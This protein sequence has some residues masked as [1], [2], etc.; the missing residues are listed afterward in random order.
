MIMN[1]EGHAAG[2]LT[3]ACNLYLFT[4]VLSF[5]AIVKQ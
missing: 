1:Y 4:C 2:S 3:A 5:F